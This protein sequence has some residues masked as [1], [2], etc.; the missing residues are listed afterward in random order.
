MNPEEHSRLVQDIKYY[1]GLAGVDPAYIY[2][3]SMAD[4]FDDKEGL[5]PQY[6][7]GFKRQAAKGKYGLA[8]FG[9][10]RKVS[11]KLAAMVGF[12]TRHFIYARYMTVDQIVAEIKEGEPPM[13]TCV[14]VPS[15]QTKAEWKAELLE[16]WLHDRITQRLQ[17]VV[18]IR[19][20]DTIAETMGDQINDMIE[21]YFIPVLSDT[22]VN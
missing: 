15:F 10:H 3:I 13:M 9:R 14:C 12:L 19:N 20:P 11:E 6:A 4:F 18:A 21:D 8:L 7:I 17:T 2:G 1:A 5:V 22:S 16:G